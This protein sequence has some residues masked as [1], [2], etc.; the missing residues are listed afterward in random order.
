MEGRFL[1]DSEISICKVNVHFCSTHIVHQYVSDST[2]PIRVFRVKRHQFS[3]PGAVQWCHDGQNRPARNIA[4][5]NY[6]T[7][8]SNLRKLCLILDAERFCRIQIHKCSGVEFRVTPAR[9][10]RAD[11][12]YLLLCNINPNSTDD[13]IKNYVE[14]ICDRDV[15]DI[16]F[17]PDHKVAR[18][19]VEKPPGM[20]TSIF[21]IY[22][23]QWY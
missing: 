11:P 9:P 10:K 3:K 6:S 23:H 17:Q 18:I 13:S 7:T 16:V 20:Y 19:A 12:R 8:P 15:E 2:A 14:I 1:P 21:V 5:Q 4:S 22:S